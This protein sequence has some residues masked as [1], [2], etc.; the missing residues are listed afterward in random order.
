MDRSRPFGAWATDLRVD[1]RS[2]LARRTGFWRSLVEVLVASLLLTLIG[3]LIAPVLGSPWIEIISYLSL[4]VYVYG[5]WR[6]SPGSGGLP[7]R[8]AR[9]LAWGLLLALC[10]WTLAVICVGLGLHSGSFFGINMA[11]VHL[12]PALLLYSSLLVARSARSCWRG[13]SWRCGTR[14]EPNCAGGSRT[15]TCS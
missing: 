8:A 13:P 2:A 15:P 9:S 12:S 11:E 14:A 3:Y 7:R 5:A 10:T 1:P 4:G 6:L